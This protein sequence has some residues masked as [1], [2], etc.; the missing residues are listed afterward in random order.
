MNKL[1][2]NKKLLTCLALALAFQIS[3]IIAGDNATAA[4]KENKK[5]VKTAKAAKEKETPEKGSREAYDKKMIEM[6]KLFSGKKAE[7]SKKVRSEIEDILT[8]AATQA[9][10]KNYADAVMV[11]D[12]IE[13]ILTGKKAKSEV[14][15][16]EDEETGVVKNYA[17]DVKDNKIISAS[18]GT[19]EEIVADGKTAQASEVAP[20]TPPDGKFN[21]K[22]LTPKEQKLFNDIVPALARAEKEFQIHQNPDNARR[23]TRLRRVF[24]SLKK[25]GMGYTVDQQMLDE[26]TKSE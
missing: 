7:L 17:F 25:K 9:R 20:T 24:Y 14:I 13:K 16:V 22:R 26:L 5:A 3:G 21:I 10:E 15:K 4:E 6:V 18:E 12:E 11:L 1:L 8:I 19:E 23:V 2:L